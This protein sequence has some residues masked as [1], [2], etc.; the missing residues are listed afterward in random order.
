MQP[1]S[2][3]QEHNSF[4]VIQEPA[5]VDPNTPVVPP[6]ADN[7]LHY[8]KFKIFLDYVL[9]IYIVALIGLAVFLVWA[10]LVE[11]G[12]TSS[13]LSAM[14]YVFI[15]FP[16]AVLST[17]TSI[18]AII[19]ILPK[20]KDVNLPQKLKKSAILNLVLS[21]IVPLAIFSPFIFFD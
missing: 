16:L 6:P 19:R 5:Q 20:L 3:D 13:L 11:P 17:C 12:S 7:E 1:D 2:Q 14:Y 10:A 18:V 4:P 9:T 15:L 8:K 21:M